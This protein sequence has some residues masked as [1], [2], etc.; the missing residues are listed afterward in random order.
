MPLL[1]ERGRLFGR[2]N[3]I[4]AA[5]GAFV[6]LLLPIGF[7]AAR[8]FRV[9]A[10]VVMTVEP[11]SQPAG[12]ARRVRLAGRNFRSYLT[13]YVGSAG[14]PL[15]LAPDSPAS[16]DSRRLTLGKLLI[17][18]STIVEIQLPDLPAGA[19][20]LYLYDETQ[21]V[22]RL[23]RAFTLT[24]PAIER[25]A[26]VRVR[27]RF[28]VAS[29]VRHLVREGDVESV[30]P[31][32]SGAPAGP[33]SSPGTMTRVRPVTERVP[34]TL[35]AAGGWSAEVLE[36]EIDFPASQNARGEWEHLDQI[37]RAGERIAFKTPAY[38]MDGV[39]GEVRVGPDIKSGR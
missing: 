33:A 24:A 14:E 32:P 19:Y 9:P 18:T 15:S 3:I 13:V 21:E 22:A 28:V 37:L 17:Q 39:I 16:A 4:D 31:G 10:P 29:E 36:A 7:T 8:L 11:A 20:D 2:L 30:Q 26:L 23:S 12:P 25:R 27:A 35:D 34:P 6:L 38:R 1:D 5:L